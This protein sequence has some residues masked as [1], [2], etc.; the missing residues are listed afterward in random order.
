M[1]RR[2]ARFLRQHGASPREMEQAE[3][4]GWLTLLTIDRMLVRD[5]A[6]Y[7]LTELARRAG[8][9]VDTAQRLWRAQGFADPPPGAATFGDDAVGALCVLVRRMEP[10]SLLGHE[11]S[12]FD[13]LLRDVRVTSGGLAR[14]AE[15][16]SDQLIDAVHAARATGM[17]DEQIALRLVDAVDWPELL[18]L[19]E[20]GLRLQVR[21]AMWRK[22]GH[23]GRT[24]APT[25]AV[26]FLDLVRYT[27]ISQELEP[28]DLGDL[29]LRFEDVTHDTIA[30]LGGRLV[31]TIGDEV[32]FVADEPA[33][34]A[35]I[36]LRL[37]EQTDDDD[38]LPE[39]RAGLAYGSV[40]ARDGDYYG[41]VV[42]LA[43][44][45]VEIARR[46][47][48]VISDSTHAALADDPAFAFARLRTRRIRDIGRVE[49]W[50]LRA[51][52]RAP[53]R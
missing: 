21:A 29:V 42:N 19:Y 36:A 50:A 12:P 17:T 53:T 35:R 6:R 11:P 4:E 52:E 44:R 10:L 51:G 33:V 24:E 43:H 25:L 30:A 3:R 45:L 1:N 13:R 32:M 8:T 41:T 31:K 26:G 39:A 28:G 15:N 37:T 34:A 9:D 40:I 22:L 16:A 46:G 23:D 27:A 20:F 7:D 47:T 49:S 2:L 48:I 14:V 18:R 5:Q 38:V